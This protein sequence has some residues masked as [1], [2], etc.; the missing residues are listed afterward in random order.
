MYIIRPRRMV[1]SYYLDVYYLASA[2]RQE[3]YLNT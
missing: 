3:Y 2:V 1:I